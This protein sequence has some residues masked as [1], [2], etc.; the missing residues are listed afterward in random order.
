MLV[1]VLIFSIF[2]HKIAKTPS[3]FL[4]KQMQTMTTKSAEETKRFAE[5]LASKITFP[6]VICLYGDLGSGKTTFTKGFAKA[7]GCMEKDIKSPTYTFVRSYTLRKSSTDSKSEN[8]GFSP[9]VMLHHFDFYRIHEP[10]EL[11]IHDIEEIFHQK[12]A[13]VIIEWPERISDFLP[14]KRWNIQFE[15]KDENTRSLSISS[16]TDD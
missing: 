14:T 11:L 10:D 2:Y 13:V 7:L 4:A 16:P 6:A 9:I 8:Q 1:L 15:I 12:N 5:E 3:N